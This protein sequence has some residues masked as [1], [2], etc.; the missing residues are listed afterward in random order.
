MPDEFRIEIVTAE[1]V[2]EL[3]FFCCKS[4]ADT[5]RYPRKLGWLKDRFSEWMRIQ[6]LYQSSQ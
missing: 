2:G 6:I 4:K 5:P 1:D 3:G